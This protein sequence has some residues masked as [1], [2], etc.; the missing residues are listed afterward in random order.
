MKLNLT[1]N[2]G[3]VAKRISE[4]GKQGRFAAATSLTR[5]AKEDVKPGIRQLM[6]TTFDRPTAYTLNSTVVK[7]AT[8]ANLESRVW[9]KDDIWGRGTPAGRY[10][11]P[12]IFGGRRQ[13]KGME[14]LLQAARLMPAGWIA[15]P[16]VGAQ[17]DGN[18]N[19]KRSQIVQ[20]MSQLRMQRGAGYESRATGSQRSNR[21]IARQGVTYFATPALY[22]GLKPGVYIKRKTGQASTI[23]PVFLFLSQATYR[24]ILKFFETGE[25]LARDRFPVYWDEEL[26]KAIASARL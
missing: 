16:S 17:L 19:V 5:V 8:K 11:G 4:L 15:V 26:A 13:Q 7:I 25:R 20:I 3:D 23:R 24:P 10:L 6:A 1:S 22:R 9:L 12:Q 21:T 18:G 2:A 14:R